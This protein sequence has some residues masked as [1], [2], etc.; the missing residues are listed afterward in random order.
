[1]FGRKVSL[2]RLLGFEAG[3]DPGW[4]VLASLVAWSLSTGYFPFRY[5]ELSTQSYWIMGIVG[6][7]GCLSP[8]WPTSAATPWWRAV[9]G[10]PCRGSRSL[11]SGALPRCTM[12]RPA[13]GRNS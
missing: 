3:I 11:S 9:R 5:R 6:A 7:W 2:F 10:C 12:S 1:M 4:L 13:P 8:S